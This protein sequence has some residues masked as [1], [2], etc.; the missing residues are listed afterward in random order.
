MHV[1]WPMR[2]M[3]HV[4]GVVLLSCSAFAQVGG[5]TATLRG[6]VRDE[7][8]GG[9]PGATVTL[10][11]VR[12]SAAR[13]LV[14]DER[15]A[16]T[17]A[18]LFPATYDLKI[19]IVGFKTYAQTGIT[20]AP[21]DTLGLDAR[22]TLGPRIETVLV[23]ASADLVQTDTGAREGRV[24]GRQIDSLSVIGRSP[25]ELLRILPGVVAPDQ[26]QLESVSFYGGA[27]ATQSYSLNGI[28]S[29]H[30]TVSLDGSNLIDIGPNNGVIVGLNNDMVQEVKI[31]SSNF[32]AEYGTGGINI[33]AV[34]KAGSSELHGTAYWY[35]RDHRLSANDRSNTIVGIEKPRSGFFYPGG[36]VGGPIVVPGAAYTRD[37]DRVFFWV[38]LEAQRQKV[39]SG[40][41]LST[42]ISPRARTGDLSEFLA[43]R[44]QNLNHPAV[45]LI[46]GGFPGA[47]TPAPNNDLRPY[48]TPL[49][50]ALASLYPLPN[51]N[52]PDN[53]Y[54]YIYSALEPTNRV[55]MK[56]RVDWNISSNTKAYV[57]I[58]RD[59]EDVENPRGIWWRGDLAVATPGEST[60][61]GRSYAGNIVQVLNQTLTN[62][63]LVSFSR[64]TLDNGYRDPSRIRA[65]ALGVE[66]QGLFPNQSP[67]VPM[68]HIYSF[69][70]GQLGNYAPGPAD[71][72][73]YNDELLFADK[74]TKVRG[75]HAF[76]FGAGAAR[77]QKQE[78]FYNNED[79]TF[80]FA[81]GFTPG[82]T[83]SQIGDLLVGRPF[84]ILQGTR[85]T[86]GRFR[87]WNLDG[88]AQNSWKI[89]SALTLD[90]GVRVGYWTNDAEVS[91]LG[92]WFDPST[93]DPRAGTFL[94]A[95]YT[96][97][98]G[99][100]Y[101]AR[102]QAPPG[103]LDNRKP[104]AL[105]R[106]NLAWSIG[107]DG[108]TLLRGGYGVFVNRPI[109]DI[110]KDAA[111]S[112]PP[113][114]YNLIANAFYDTN[115][116]GTGLTYETVHLIPFSAL[117]GSQSISTLTPH[118]FTFPRTDSYSASYA[119]RIFWRQVV[120]AAYVGT[121]GRHLV[122]SLNGN[123]VPFGALES[124]VVGNADLSI[125]VN[126]GNL[127][128]G[129]VNAMRPFP[130]YGNITF[131]DF[132]G[133]SRY[134]SLQVT[135]SRRTGGRLQ[136]FVAYTLS[137]TTGTLNGEYSWRDPFDESR[138][139]GV[140]PEDRMHILNVSWNAFVPDAARGFLDN[141]FG[142]GLLNGWQLSGISTAV[143]G[144]PIHLVFTGDAAG[145][146]VSQ[147]YFGTP[148]VVGP[149]VT[150]FGGGGNGLAPELTCD[151]SLSGSAVGEKILNI[152]CVRVPA[153]GTNAPLI[154]RYDLRT[155]AH[156]NHDVTLFKN[157]VTHGAQKLQLRAGFFDIFNMAY[158][159]NSPGNAD[160]D[161]ALDTTCNRRVDHV[162]NGIGGFADGVCDPT[163]GYS[164]T[165]NTR[166]NFGKIRLKRGHRV[167]ELVVKYYF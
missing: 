166:A 5:T 124:G 100:R 68:N 142:R 50:R 79:G 102:G 14:S 94:D 76:K 20:L 43:A 139:Y 108:S 90:Y 145:P 34:T 105:P 62:E 146:G 125:P 147:A 16:F 51:H 39:D 97:L 10:L 80:F 152:N 7:S 121:S 155:P 1:R 143:S 138:T 151:P 84:Q 32:A 150:G 111:L 69:G 133:R 144:I 118:S 40:S 77:L 11:D 29:S 120:E 141:A 103:L 93:Y 19:E 127:D 136:Y 78:N 98:N 27:N 106:V 65:D 54:N 148:D 46:P 4:V 9:V 47:G 48:V 73:A 134:R 72:Y 126:R 6:T 92:T 115:L 101:A 53:R 63:V 66:F 129:V 91:R 113:N 61:R 163:G 158:T 99:V 156:V 26:N 15:G 122:S 95:Q 116:A 71:V 56:A 74:L 60:N 85:P 52:D 112:V 140:L 86:N 82:S 22:L 18:G 36:N 132:E 33:S 157:F 2:V 59:T 96:Q 162:P 24:T 109:N 23:T 104:F 75:A 3:S 38:G 154:P 149:D 107:R 31:Q 35:G 114:A 89:K 117:F 135:L 167:I 25:L 165:P 87:E 17:F 128:P 123:A 131:H 13:T 42:T 67:Y 30:N 64:L 49:G 44:G 153:F 37:R 137:R 110:D 12:T 130:A 55:E 8:G 28:R 41:V 81:P 45:V 21:N 164:F 70:G 83:G 161:L 159:S 57:R 88:F 160:V 58:A 119:R